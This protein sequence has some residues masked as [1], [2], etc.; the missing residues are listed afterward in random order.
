MDYI[1]ALCGEP[2]DSYEFKE[3]GDYTKEEA[4]AFFNDKGCHCCEFGKDQEKIELYQRYMASQNKS[5]IGL[6][7]LALDE[8]DGDVE[9]AA[10]L[11]EE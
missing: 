3:G 8:C 10:Y 4:E 9:E 2:C 1:C 6:N 11:L 5:R 7:R